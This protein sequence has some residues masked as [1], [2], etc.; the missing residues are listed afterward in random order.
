LS[1]RK[2]KNNIFSSDSGEAADVIPKRDVMKDDFNWQVPVE[3]VPVPSQGK[4]YSQ[5]HPLHLKETIEVKAMTAK[6]EDILSSRALIQEGTAVTHL[7]KSCLI[8]RDVDPED[9]LIG[10]RNALMIAIRITGYGSRYRVVAKC[11]SCGNSSDQDFDLSDLTIKRLLIEPVTSG[12]NEFSFNLPITKKTVHFKFI[13]G[14]D[15]KDISVAAERRKK[16]MPGAKIDNNITS[17]LASQIVSIDGV[18]DRSKINMFIN[19]MPAQDSRRLR[20]YIVEN[21][22]GIN[23]K[24]QMDCP[25]CGTVSEVALPLGAG[26]FWPED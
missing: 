10:D 18:T 19:N 5:E 13:N 9:M 26:F 7:I 11:P 4:V 22:P 1:K 23:M 2:D 3:T 8:N 16:L 21:E 14:K 17:R 25:H 6:E 12:L 15:E 20:K 24:T